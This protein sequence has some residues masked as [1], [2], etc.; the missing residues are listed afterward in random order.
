MAHGL[1]NDD[2]AVRKDMP[3][4]VALFSNHTEIVT[5]GGRQWRVASNG[6][7]EMPKAA[8]LARYRSFS[9]GWSLPYSLV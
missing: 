2:E 8:T 9:S 7:R 3:L 6:Q 5:H 4:D 1:G